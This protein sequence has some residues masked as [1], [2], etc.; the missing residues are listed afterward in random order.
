MIVSTR[1]GAAGRQHRSNTH[2]V[3]SVDVGIATVQ[4]HRQDHHVASLGGSVQRCPLCRLARQHTLTQAV[5]QTLDTTRA[6]AVQPTHRSSHVGVSPVRQQQ[7]TCHTVAVLGREEQRGLSTHLPRHK[8]T[9]SLDVQQLQHGGHRASTWTTSE[10][11][12]VAAAAVVSR[13][14]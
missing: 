12:T 2:H 13:R 7:L 10:R 9:V 11:R 5:S 6:P 3:S 4:Q 14:R 8:Q 1:Q